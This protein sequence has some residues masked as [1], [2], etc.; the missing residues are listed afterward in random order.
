MGQLR[1]VCKKLEDDPMNVSQGC[2]V[3]IHYTLT[4]DVGD[5]LDTSSGQGHLS[6][7]H[8]FGGIIPGLEYAL[9]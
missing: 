1:P 7:L 9:E 2:V 5:I 8:G 4:N 6:Y 3:S